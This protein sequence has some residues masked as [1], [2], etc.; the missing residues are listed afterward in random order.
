MRPRSG[1]SILVR[2]AV[3]LAAAGCAAAGCAADRPFDEERAMH[4]LVAQV[5]A[6]ARVPGTPAHEATH[7]KLRA[8]FAETADRVT[9]HRFR[10]VSP[11][12]STSMELLTL[13]GVFNEASPVRILFGAH[14]DSRAFADADPDSSLRRLPVPG[15][16]DGA[17]GA[18]VLLEI[19]SALERRP[20]AIG[21]DLV[22]FDGEDQGVHGDPR[23]FAL[24][25]QR[26]VQ[27]FPQYRPAFAIILDMV[28][29][30]G[31]SIPREANSMMAA[32]PLANRVWEIGRKAGIGVLADS[33]GSPVYDDHIAFLEAG[34]PA[35]DLIDLA[36]PRWHTRQ[37][38]PEYCSP[39]SLGEVG[40]LLLAVLRDA[41]KSLSP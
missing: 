4:H 3:V 23:S 22:L 33:L 6:G 8:H 40:R 20:P 28:G 11:L 38:L 34:I 12:D 1:V 39:R 16:N 37:D 31:L 9:E 18:A 29:R 30:E 7:A 27:D 19:A 14:W 41:E 36:D 25:S 2:S 13:V 35:L 21:V 26:F 24:G 5:E 10:A 15:A 32:A 17:S